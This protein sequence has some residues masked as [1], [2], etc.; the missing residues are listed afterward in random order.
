MCGGWGPCEVNGVT[1]PPLDADTHGPRLSPPRSV[2]SG[3][4]AGQLWEWLFW[5]LS[6]CLAE[7]GATKSLKWGLPP[8]CPVTSLFSLSNVSWS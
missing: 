7:G 8:A 5:S 1:E 3:L 6:C 4:P 2:L